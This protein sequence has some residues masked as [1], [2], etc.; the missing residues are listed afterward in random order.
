MNKDYIKQYIAVFLI[1][2]M[3]RLI[4]IL[5]YPYIEKL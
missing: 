5:L 2:I 1:V 3:G 4:G